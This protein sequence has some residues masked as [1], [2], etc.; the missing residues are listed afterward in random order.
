MENE[1]IKEN[2]WKSWN[3]FQKTA[4]IIGLL[5]LIFFVIG[6]VD[7]V[8]TKLTTTGYSV[9]YDV[10]PD[11][12]ITI[13][14]PST[15]HW[16]SC[17]DEITPL[18]IKYDL[19]SSTAVDLIFTPTMEDAN[20]LSETSKHYQVCYQPSILKN[21]GSCNI[22][23]KGCIVILNKNLNDATVSLKYTAL[24]IES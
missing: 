20:N 16:I 24:K 5:V 21:K 22:D 4:F 17:W 19:T 15:Q 6:V 18:T 12:D 23:G 14:V 9:Y 1:G 7:L 3:P 2:K 10:K 8:R 13:S 11:K